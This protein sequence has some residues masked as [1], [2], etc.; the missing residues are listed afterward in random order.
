[1]LQNSGAVANDMRPG[2]RGKT[3]LRTLSRL[4]GRTAAAKRARVLVQ[5]WT[6]A[7]GGAPSPVQSMALAH[8]AATQVILEDAQAKRLRGDVSITPEQ[9][10]KL[11]NIADR[12]RRQLALPEPGAQKRATGPGRLAWEGK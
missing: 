9:I 8:A 5:V 6:A 1:M 11:S 3:K 7:L 12:A 10:V 4:D 2:R